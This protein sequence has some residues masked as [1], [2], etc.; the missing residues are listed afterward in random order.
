MYNRHAPLFQGRT[1]VL[2]SGSHGLIPFLRSIARDT[3][4]LIGSLRSTT[5]N[6]EWADSFILCLEDTSSTTSA[7]DEGLPQQL[8]NENC[9]VTPAAKLT[10][11]T[12]SGDQKF[13]VGDK[14]SKLSSEMR[15]TYPLDGLLSLCSNK[16]QQFAQFILVSQTRRVHLMIVYSVISTTQNSGTTSVDGVVSGVTLN[17]SGFGANELLCGLE[18]WDSGC[19]VIVIRAVLSMNLQS[20]EY[21]GTVHL[22]HDD[23]R[24]SVFFE[25]EVRRR[26]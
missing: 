26:G 12:T 11:V 18:A 23:E 22:Q 16:R 14:L 13:P 7:E 3:H 4:V 25:C 20:D 17:L 10:N 15:Q 5:S 19:I 8:P 9:V 1:V 21:T 2:R 6:A 24:M